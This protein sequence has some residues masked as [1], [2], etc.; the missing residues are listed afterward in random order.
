MQRVQKKEAAEALGVL[1]QSPAAVF[2]FDFRGLT[3]A[4]ITDLRRRVREVG[5]TYR[6]V[7]NSTARFALRDAGI[8]GLDNHLVGMTGLAWSNDDPVSLAKALHEGTREF[9][10][11]AF[12]GGIV[13]DRSVGPELFEALA[14]LPSRETLRGQFVSLVAA[15]LQNLVRVLGGVPRQLLLVLKAA[16]EKASGEAAAP[17][18]ATAADGTGEAAV[19]EGDA[20]EA[21]PGAGDA[22]EASVDEEAGSEGDTA[23]ASPDETTGNEAPPVE[24]AGAEAA[25]GEAAAEEAA[26]E[27]KA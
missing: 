11:F 1:L 12:R 14:G 18:D 4:E 25:S 2:S 17:R 5:G 23:E 9:D 7:K 27:G 19:R 21:A 10:G 6:V 16:E 3:V 15:P 22:S 8:T 24:A 26:S 13:Q 20:A